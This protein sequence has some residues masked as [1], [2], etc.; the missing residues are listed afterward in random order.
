MAEYTTD[1]VSASM[2]TGHCGNPTSTAAPHAPTAPKATVPQTQ[3]PSPQ[4]GA[5]PASSTTPAPRK[6]KSKTQP[7][8]E[9]TRDLKGKGKDSSAEIVVYKVPG[10]ETRIVTFDPVSKK[11][12]DHCRNRMN[13]FVADFQNK[14][15]LQV[16]GDL[17]SQLERGALRIPAVASCFPELVNRS[18]LVLLRKQKHAPL[19]TVSLEELR[20]RLRGISRKFRDFSSAA[21][22]QSAHYDTKVAELSDAIKH[23]TAGGESSDEAAL[24]AYRGDSAEPN[25]LAKVLEGLCPPKGDKADGNELS[26]A[27]GVSLAVTLESHRIQLAT[28]ASAGYAN[29]DAVSQAFANMITLRQ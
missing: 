4:T 1:A 3:Q 5:I 16:E 17:T 15:S 24:Q 29:S 28:F 27:L 10:G 12:R 26:K 14:F 23:A 8:G 25:I 11:E 7:K 9:E 18:G 21:K 19:K 6:R 2:H 20:A 22:D 13:E